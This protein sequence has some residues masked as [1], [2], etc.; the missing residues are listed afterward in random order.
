ME[1]IKRRCWRKWK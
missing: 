1:E